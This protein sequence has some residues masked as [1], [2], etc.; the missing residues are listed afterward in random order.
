MPEDI[1]KKFENN[2]KKQAT[3]EKEY[4]ADEQ[5]ELEEKSQSEIFENT[6]ANDNANFTHDNANINASSV[7]KV[8]ILALVS[9]VFVGVYKH[10]KSTHGK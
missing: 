8:L 3:K 4:K 9:A 1:T 5:K 10:I 6:N 7:K 2:L